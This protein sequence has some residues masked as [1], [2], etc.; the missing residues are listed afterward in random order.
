RCKRPTGSRHYSYLP[1]NDLL[2]HILKSL[3]TGT[4]METDLFVSQQNTD[5][6]RLHL[7]VLPFPGIVS[8]GNG[9]D[10]HRVFYSFAGSSSPPPR[11]RE[12]CGVPNPGAADDFLS[13]INPE[14]LVIK[15]GFAE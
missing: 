1:R 6:S 13:V 2:Q 4:G 11:D 10:R 7:P 15:Q 3:A 8:C 9:A 12:P 5:D 14:S